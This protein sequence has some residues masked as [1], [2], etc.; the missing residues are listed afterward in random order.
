MTTTTAQPPSTL[1]PPW[2]RA[3]VKQQHGHWPLGRSIRIPLAVGIPLLVGTLVNQELVGLFAAI[4]ALLPSVS[5]KVAPYR[6]RF[7]QLAVGLAMSVVGYVVIAAL[8]QHAAVLIPAVGLLALVAGIVSSISS[9]WSGGALQMLLLASLAAH[10]EP[11]AGIAKVVVGLVVGAGWTALLLA[12]EFAVERSGPDRGILATYLRAVGAVASAPAESA[13]SGAESAQNEPEPAQSGAESTHRGAESTQIVSSAVPDVLN[14]DPTPFERA[15]AAS[16]AA[17]TAAYGALIRVRAHTQGRSRD[18]DHRAL[19]LAALG[20]LN[21]SVLAMRLTHPATPLT[22]LSAWLDQVADAVLA[23]RPVPAPPTGLPDPLDQ[24]TATLQHT[25]NR[26]ADPATDPVRLPTPHRTSIWRRIEHLAVGR[27]TLGAALRLALCMALAMAAT[28]VIPGRSYWVP[29]TVAV[30]LKPDFGSVF[31]RAVLRCLGTMVGVGL[32]WV[33]L[34]L[35]PKGPWLILVIAVLVVFLPWAAQVSYA[36]LMVFVTPMVVVLIDLATP[37]KTVDFGAQRL[38]D[39][40]IGSAIVLIFGYLLWPSSRR[41]DVP[42][43]FSSALGAV[44]GLLRAVSEA[45]ADADTTRETRHGAYRSLSDLRTQLQRSLAEPPPNS[46][47]AASWFP[48]VTVAERLV[49]Q[50]VAL[51]AVRPRDA[52]LRHELLAR[53]DWLTQAVAAPG[54]G[55]PT[56]EAA[57]LAPLDRELTRLH[58]ELARQLGA[59]AS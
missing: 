24:R 8:P 1:L 11:L 21:G 51:L 15:R 46:R 18:Q 7:A 44:A 10:L 35:I 45:S 16:T 14:P 26:T 47:I 58:R 55:A 56:S 37:G 22:S 2:V 29:L 48:L 12:V 23:G 28:T 53:A 42:A 5:E 17:R 43:A 59:T 41:V 49:D 39:T 34:L 54:V 6:L 9:R 25:L 3:L 13:Q 32:G 20:D 50:C 57:A 52:A 31:A 36:M 4:G 19:V 27:A 30:V 38:M 33:L 40:V